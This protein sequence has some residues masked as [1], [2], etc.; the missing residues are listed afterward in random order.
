[1]ENFF[2]HIERL[3]AYHDYVVVPELGGFVVQNQSA[4]IFDDKITPPR[5]TIGFNALMNHADGLLT[6]EVA[7]AEAITYR[8]A[9]EKV[10]RE[11]ESI[12]RQF[13]END[14]HRFGNLGF[15]RRTAEG[16]LVFT[17]SSTVSFLPANHCKSDI[18]IVEKSA[19]KL[20]SNKHFSI[21][22]TL[23]Y[24]AAIALLFGVSLFLPNKNIDNV[25]QNANF[26]NF[27]F[28][29][30]PEVKPIPADTAKIEI[31]AVETEKAFEKETVI[32]NNWGKYDV[33]VA[34][35]STRNAAEKY[36]NE[37][38]NNDFACTRILPAERFFMISLQNFTNKNEALQYM[39]E[40]RDSNP[41]FKQAWVLCK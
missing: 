32:E 17:P 5:D 33:I 1:M 22:T 24:A 10:Q 41:K 34:C 2:A 12:K 29:Q 19:L 18:Y 13:N 4:E 37:L 26:L 38:I 11:V 31:V 35:L 7:R 23:R 39:Q 3:L 6:L 36:T 16:T 28:P 40:L 30:I 9:V 15:F 27:E 8:Q 25:S 14:F 21:A 20:N